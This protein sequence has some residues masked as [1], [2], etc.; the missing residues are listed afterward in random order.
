ME[1]AFKALHWGKE[2]EI[3]QYLQPLT[4]QEALEMLGEYRGRAL[5]IAGGTD[6][7]PLLRRG[8]FQ[9]DALVDISGLPGMRYIEADGD[10]IC[11]GGLVTHT[12]VGSSSLIQE[13]A[14]LLAYAAN[15]VGSPQI[16]NVATVAGNLVSGQPAA[17]T[18]LPLLAL[19]ATVTIR[20]KAGKREVP[21]TQFFLDQGRTVLDCSQEILTQIRFPALRKN[22][23]GCCLRLSG[24][25][26]LALPIFALAAVV[27]VEPDKRV[28][29]DAA[30]AIGPVA[31]IP[32]RAAKAEAALRGAPLSKK[33]LEMAA[34]SAFEESSPRSSL[35]RG[36]ME[37]RK[38]MVKVFV[39]RGLSRALA[40]AG[41]AIGEGG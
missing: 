25:K 18:A 40:D 38:E 19:N 14:R 32:F 7:I 12:Q 31:P 22:Q 1:S 5:I 26:S 30:I 39:R 9:V 23:G 28:I 21:L 4:I 3:K 17:D 11:L 27:A 20:S 2:I 41:V 16:R 24:R 15:A 37:Y 33:I 13:R 8:E 36:S 35:L 10:S 29:Q 34:Q 6:V